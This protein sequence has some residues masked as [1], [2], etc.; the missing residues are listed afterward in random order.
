[1]YVTALFPFTGAWAGEQAQCGWRLGYVPVGA[2]PEY[3][4]TFT[5][6]VANITDGTLDI[7]SDATWNYASAWTAEYGADE[8][9]VTQNLAAATAVLD[10]FNTVKN[11]V[12]PFVTLGAIKIAL[13]QPDGAYAFPSSVWSLKTP[14]AGTGGTGVPAPPEVAVATTLRSPVLGRRG[15]GRWY[16]PAPQMM[17]SSMSDGKV[18]T[19]ARS[20]WVAAGVSLVQ[21]FDA[22]GAGATD[23]FPVVGVAS[24]TSA[25]MVRPA[26]VR[27]GDHFDVQRRRQHQVDEVYTS[28]P[29]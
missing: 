8:W 23:F 7:G 12:S 10:Y 18:S 16:L 19:T 6:Q 27:V 24:A 28:T 22:I 20:E 14:V 5:P 15:R 17:S 1:M 13:I 26:E 21:D 29:L 4:A 25:T 11:R 2:E 9:G 3:G